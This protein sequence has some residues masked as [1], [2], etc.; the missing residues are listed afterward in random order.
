MTDKTQS[1]RG[2]INIGSTIARRLRL[3][4]ISTLEDL[5]AITPAG[6]YRRLQAAHPGKT[7]PVCYYLYSLQGALDNKDWR[8]LSPQ[9]K[10]RL[11]QAIKQMPE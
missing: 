4:G 9:T 11:R 3:V 2:T 8:E 7:L 10:A 5:R 6:A 1:L